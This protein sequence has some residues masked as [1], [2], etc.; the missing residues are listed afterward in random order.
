[1]CSLLLSGK[2][3]CNTNHV[4]DNP[5]TEMSEPRTER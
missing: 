4:G 3:Y 1:L 5:S 2:A